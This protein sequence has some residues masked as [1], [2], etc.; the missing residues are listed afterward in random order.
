MPRLGAE[1][2]GLSAA[3][4]GVGQVAA[5]RDPLILSD[6]ETRMKGTHSP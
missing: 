5:A 1:R 2:A 4:E 6:F 3:T